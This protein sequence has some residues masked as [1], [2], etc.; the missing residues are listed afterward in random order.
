MN[1]KELY[2]FQV[3]AEEKSITKAAK[4]LYMTPQGISKIVKN[5]EAE[6]GCELF[7]RNQ[8]GRELTESGRCFLE[9]ALRIEEEYKNMRKELLHIRQ[10]EHGVVDILSAYGIM[11]LLTPECIQAFKKKYP[12][13]EFYYRE[14]PDRQVERLFHEREGNVAFSIAGYEEEDAE[15]DVM[16][17]ETFPVKLLVNE[18]HPLGLQK[19]V[20]IQDLRGQPLYIE[21]GEFKIH[22]MIVEKCRAAGFEPNIVFETSGFS[23]CHKMVKQNK[24][25]SVTVD[26]VFDDMKESGMKLIPFSDGVYEWKV[27]MLTRHGEAVGHGVELFREHVTE[28]LS[29]IREG[30]IKR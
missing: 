6:C 24:G 9:Y 3:V 23:L 25:I 19:S 10:R 17:L 4:K 2:T 5:L 21:S 12:E 7:F 26:F 13:I 28:W 29:M 8:S 22:H 27:C 30:T 14:Y 16:E 18:N 1:I 11:R 20:T 15:Y